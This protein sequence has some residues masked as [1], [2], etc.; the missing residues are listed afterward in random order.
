LATAESYQLLPDMVSLPIMVMVAQG[1]M[2]AALI[3]L[4]V[5]VVGFDIY[6]LEDIARTDQVYYLPRWA[7]ALL[8]LVVSPWAGMV[9][10]TIGRSH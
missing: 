4:L 2:L 7:W 10:L 9:Y 3:P 1:T 6:C 8:C 5:V